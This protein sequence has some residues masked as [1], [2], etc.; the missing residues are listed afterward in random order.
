MYCGESREWGGRDFIFV[1]LCGK[2]GGFD[3]R[4]RFFED[5]VWDFYRYCICV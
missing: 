2:V 5:D 3:G 4:R 1:K